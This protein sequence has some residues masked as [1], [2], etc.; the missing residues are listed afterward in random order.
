[1]GRS[2]IQ[3]PQPLSPPIPV[4]VIDDHPAILSVVAAFIQITPPLLLAGVAN[5]RAEGLKLAATIAPQIILLDMEFRDLAFLTTGQD[6]IIHQLHEQAPSSHILALS[7]LPDYALC[8]AS[9][10]AGVDACLYKDLSATQLREAIL[11]ICAGLPLPL[12]DYACTA[13]Q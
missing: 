7:S 8:Q 10:V 5:T 9:L 2:A 1:M 4:L 12:G 6:T 13:L 3:A 11:A